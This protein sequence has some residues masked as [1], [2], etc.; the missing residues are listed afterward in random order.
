[1]IWNLDHSFVYIFEVV[2][3]ATR[4]SNRRNFDRMKSQ[5]SKIL[6]FFEQNI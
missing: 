2:A 4:M 5:M 6:L 3:I 1:M